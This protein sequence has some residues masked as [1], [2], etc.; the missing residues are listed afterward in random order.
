MTRLKW[1]CFLLVTAM[2][3]LFFSPLASAD[4]SIAHIDLE[5]THD[6]M[7]VT[8]LDLPNGEATLIQGHEK[9]ILVNAGG[10]QSEKALKAQLKINGVRTVDM[11]ILTNFERPYQFDVANVVQTYHIKTIL[12]TD[13]IHHAFENQPMPPVSFEPWST[14]K[15]VAL[16]PSLTIQKQS[17]S[18]SG[19]VNFILKYGSNTLLYLG[20]QASFENSLNPESI[21]KVRIVKLS[22]FGQVSFTDHV[23]LDHLDPEVAILFKQK[24]EPLNKRLLKQLGDK[25]I[26]T[27]NISHVGHLTFIFTT[28]S[29]D[30]VP[31]H[32][33]SPTY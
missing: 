31:L 28:D 3:L 26:E 10:K 12:T 9:T 25:M 5:L 27:Y 23:L 20:D 24:N 29:Y 8:F 19:D 14:T 16:F 4:T 33:S 21:P 15:P 11:L 18:R 2:C 32:S 13:R 30:A 1:H 7:A 22:H 17:E 6:K